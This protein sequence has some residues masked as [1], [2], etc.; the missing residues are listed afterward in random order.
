V[1]LGAGFLVV[2]ATPAL[3]AWSAPHPVAPGQPPAAFSPVSLSC[4]TATFCMAVDYNSG[5]ASRWNGSAW[6]TPVVI[7]PGGGLSSVSCPS[8]GFCVAVDRAG[9]A[10][11]YADGTWRAPV[12]ADAQNALGSVSCASRSFCVALDPQSAVVYDGTSWS[13]PH[14]LTSLMMSVSC[15]ASTFCVAV[16]DN[17]DAFTYDGTMWSGPAADGVSASQVS[18]PA[19]GRC[20]VAGGDDTARLADGSWRAPVNVLQDP[21]WGFDGVSCVSASFCMATAA[22][23]S[24]LNDFVPGMVEKWGGRGW[25]ASAHDQYALTAVSCTSTSFCLAV[26]NRGRYLRWSAGTAAAVRAARRSRSGA[27]SR[28]RSGHRDVRT[29]HR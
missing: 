8:A 23:D 5:T 27:R 12:K 14:Q 2:A 26:D 22:F 29:R 11:T 15:P 10:L 21:L 4:A 16:D 17:G 1:A 28:A 7:V 9:D 25:E 18:C 3:A 20:V 13:A 24:G 19:V 6:S